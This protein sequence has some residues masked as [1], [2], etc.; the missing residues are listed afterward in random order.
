MKRSQLDRIVVIVEEKN[1][2]ARH[3]LQVA[4]FESEQNALL[5][6]CMGRPAAIVIS[7]CCAG[8]AVVKAVDKRRHGAA[9][10]RLRSEEH[11]Y[12]RESRGQLVCRFLVDITQR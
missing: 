3:R 8:G 1:R 2:I 7:A 12:G 11:T 6:P 9:A 10:A 4:E 5:H